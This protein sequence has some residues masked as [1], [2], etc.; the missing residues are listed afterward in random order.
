MQWRFQSSDF[1]DLSERV[2]LFYVLSQGDG[3]PDCIVKKYQDHV[4]DDENQ[5]LTQ[6]LKHTFSDVYLAIISRITQE[7]DIENVSVQTGMTSVPMLMKKKSILDSSGE[8]LLGQALYEIFRSFHTYISLIEQIDSVDEC[9]LKKV[10]YGKKKESDN[11]SSKKL[12]KFDEIRNLCKQ[13][14]LKK[15][16]KKE[17]EVEGEKKL[18]PPRGEG[19]HEESEPLVKKVLDRASERVNIVLDKDQ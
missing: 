3:T 19:Q 5:R 11:Q 4:L 16:T 12:K 13:Q 10:W 8:V 17:S 18:L 2:K 7:D 6:T 9:D 15:D 1:N 14:A